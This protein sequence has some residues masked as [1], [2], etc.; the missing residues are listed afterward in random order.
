MNRSVIDDIS[1]ISRINA[2][3]AILQVISETTGLRFAAVARVTEDSWTAC[4]V[5]DRINFGLQVGGELDVT[6][7]LCHEIRASHQTI[8]I[9]KA[10]EDLRYCSHH[11]PKLYGFESYIS[12]PVFR[13]DGSFFGTV[14]ALDPLPAKLSEGSVLAMMES[15]AK[16]L[17]IQLEA[18]EH[19]EATEAALLDVQ[20]T[21]ELRE[22]F[23]ALL[24]HDLRNPLSSILSGAQLMMR[25]SKDAS[26]TGI[27]EHMLTATRRASR[28]VDDVLDFARGRLGNGI[29]LQSDECHELHITLT[30]IVSEMQSAHPQRAIEADIAPLGGV[31]CDADRLAQLLSNLLA[32]A[33]VH[34]SATG[35]V[36]V[37]AVIE[38]G[39]LLLSV[40]NQGEPIPADRLAQLFKPF[41]Q[42]ASNTQSGLGLGLYIANEIAMSHGGSMRVTSTAEAGTTFTFSMP[43]GAAIA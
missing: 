20:Q 17:A 1:A 27:A 13:T 12:A 30:H 6:T 31:R 18:E 14:C 16:L 40:N 33:L 8:I 29:P 7:T 39:H 2:V 35:R 24:G 28:L 19:F 11:T 10:S 21:A 15:F 41:W 25:R 43:T 9:N 36:H 26:I 37:R 42:E 22:Q 34:G 3:P 5:L 4:A 32:N 38:K 23:I